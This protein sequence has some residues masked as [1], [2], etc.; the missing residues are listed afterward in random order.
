MNCYVMFRGNNSV[1]LFVDSPQTC[2]QK[3]WS[4]HKPRQRHRTVS[5]KKEPTCF[6]M[7]LRQKS[8]DFNAVFSV[9][10]RNK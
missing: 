10:F 1:G 2:D 4:Q 8:M 6:C 9:R 7:Q 5:H 3:F